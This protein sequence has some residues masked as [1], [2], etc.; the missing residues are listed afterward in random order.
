MF[1]QRTVQNLQFE[2]VFTFG[3][4]CVYLCIC[5]GICCSVV[6]RVLLCVVNFARNTISLLLLLLLLFFLSHFHFCFF[7]LL[8][9]ISMNLRWMLEHFSI[10][11][12]FFFFIFYQVLLMPTGQIRKIGL[13]FHKSRYNRRPEIFVLNWRIRTKR[14]IGIGEKRS[15]SYI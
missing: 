9:S 8:F 15:L 12:C 7:S 10:F 14:K 5:A 11:V 1:I 6:I 2:C 3:E 13:N 4:N